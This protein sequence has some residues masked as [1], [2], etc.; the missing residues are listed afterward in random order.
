MK[1]YML[2]LCAVVILTSCGVSKAERQTQKTIKGDWTLT[3]IELPSALVDVNL[4][5]DV[6]TRCFENSDWH[7]VSNNNKGSYKLYKNDCQ[8]GTRDFRWNIEENNNEFYFTLKH[9]VDGVNIRHEKRGF[10]LKLVSLD[11]NYMVWEENT[12]YEGKP[13]PIRISFSKN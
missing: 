7:F 6:D 4:F 12:T 8:P 10:R 13:F 5:E 9:E 1:K 11:D 2:I 3:H